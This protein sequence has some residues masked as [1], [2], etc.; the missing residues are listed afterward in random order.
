MRAVVVVLALALGMTSG[1]VVSVADAR[2]RPRAQW[3]SATDEFFDRFV[4]DEG[5]TVRADQGDDTVSEG[6]AYALL[7]AVADRDRD[8]FARVWRW[9]ADHLQ[10]PDALLAWHWADGQVVD[11]MP[12]TDAD[13]DA[14]RA[15]ALAGEVFDEPAWRDE[16]T[17][18]GATVLAQETVVS[19]YGTLLVAG[20]WARR[21]PGAPVAAVVNPSYFSPRTAD[22]LASTTGDARW[23]DVHT[24]SD[25][26]LDALTE[27]TLPPDWATMD[28]GGVVHASSAPGGDRVGYGQDAAR[29]PLRYAESCA[30]DDRARVAG[31]WPRLEHARHRSTLG[32][33][34]AAAAAGV[35][36]QRRARDALLRRAED[37]E[38]TSP[39]YY[40]TAWV[41]LARV[42]LTTDRLGA[43]P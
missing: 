36:G 11:S 29:L 12:A 9:T 43:C 21:D 7:L 37:S 8:R 28:S 31:W 34:A 30:P 14:A 13:L 5:R 35:A 33:L 41:A 15:L 27:G 38:V 19:A 1:P 6:Q 22:L 20:P 16:A 18:L 40:G 17:R 26:A 3:A 24:A 2:S 4:T 10:R 25:A 39:T 42:M 23:H 32:N